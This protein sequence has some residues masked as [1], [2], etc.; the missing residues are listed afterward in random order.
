MDILRQSERQYYAKQREDICNFQTQNHKDFWSRIRKLR[1]GNKQQT[2]DSVLL[3]DGTESRD[4]WRYSEK[5]E[6]R[7]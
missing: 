3:D 2:I 7:F 5:V 4:G 6:I 1:P